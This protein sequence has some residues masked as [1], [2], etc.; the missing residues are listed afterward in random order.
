MEEEI[1]FVFADFNSAGS[2]N[3]EQQLVSIPW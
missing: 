3:L 2:V 1:F